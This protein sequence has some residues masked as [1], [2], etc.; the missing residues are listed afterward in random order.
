[1]GLQEKGE[2][3]DVDA[4]ELATCKKDSPALPKVL[5]AVAHANYKYKVVKFG[6]DPS[7][8]EIRATVCLPLEDN[9]QLPSAQ[10]GAMIK[11]L[12]GVCDDF[13]PTLEAALQSRGN[14]TRNVVLAVVFLVVATAAVIAAL[15]I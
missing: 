12:S 3:L 2:Y 8:G 11:F 6:W 13:Y 9:D 1:V 7:D 5:E 10:V 14:R 4:L 15:T